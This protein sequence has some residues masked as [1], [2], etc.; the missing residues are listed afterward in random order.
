MKKIL[1]YLLIL[2][3]SILNAQT[4]KGDI[5]DSLTKEPLPYANIVLINGKGIYSDEKGQFELDVKDNI[6]DTLKISSLGYQAK[7]F[8][9]TIFKNHNVV[10]LK[11]PL[12]AK[13]VNIEEVVISQKKINYNQKNVFGENKEGNIGMTSLV[14]YETCLYIEN[15]TQTA[16]KVKRTYIDLK[17]RDN[18]DY[19]AMFNIKFYEYDEK[20]NVPGKELYSKNIYVNPKNH[21]YRLWI[22]VEEYNIKFPKNG[23]CVGVEL[24]NTVGKVE[25]YAKFG[26]MFRYTISK[27]NRPITWSNYHNTGW[28]NGS[29]GGK[30]GFVNPMIGVEVLLPSKE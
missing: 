13:V 9:L 1:L 11:V 18:A 12:N 26:P 20:N 22:D 17:R 16:G 6:Y 3:A 30:T 15:P 23:I 10:N 14:G 19:I 27:K 24:I 4:I 28:R 21:K 8:P 2:T 5:I 29:T 7:F 25:K